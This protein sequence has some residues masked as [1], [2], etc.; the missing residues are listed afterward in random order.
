MHHLVVTG[1]FGVRPADF[2]HLPQHC[3]SAY[4]VL[5]TYV[6][7]P[8]LIASVGCP[9]LVLEAAVLAAS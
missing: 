5:L 4:P 3:G 9:V 6:G 8:V 7:Y 2:C 1:D